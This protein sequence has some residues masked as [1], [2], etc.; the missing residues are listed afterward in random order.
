M[1]AAMACASC[2][3][4]FFF[5]VQ[6]SGCMRQNTFRTI[7]S[8]Q[9]VSISLERSGKR[10]TRSD[11]R[12]LAG[13]IQDAHADLV[14][15]H[16]VRRISREGDSLDPITSLSDLTGMTYAFGSVA[17]NLD[18][19]LGNGVLTRF[20]ILEEKNLNFRPTGSD[21]QQGLLKLRLDVHGSEFILIA[22]SIPDGLSESERLLC[23]DRILREGDRDSSG[24][25]IVC[26]TFSMTPDDSAMVRLASR[27]RDCGPFAAPDSGLRHSGSMRK[28]RTDGIFVQR[29]KETMRDRL[30]T[31]LTPT[32]AKFL[33]QGPAKD[34]PL[35]IQFEFPRN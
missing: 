15:L 33:R 13:V 12:E 2:G 29:P 18:E 32:S 10:L 31:S 25:M 17:E 3:V 26:G 27:F 16:Q 7:P 11:L 24:G 23:I 8:I 20:P 35:L 6:S 5:L 9:V 28:L 1:K 34:P 30:S 19:R 21:E 22:A 4:F 14:A